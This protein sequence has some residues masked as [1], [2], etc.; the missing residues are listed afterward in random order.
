[1]I[2]AIRNRAFHFENLLK[3]NPDGKPRLSALASFNASWLLATVEPQKIIKLLNDILVSFD[4][5]LI[6]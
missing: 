5:D 3:I 6:K 1:M 4:K 2:K